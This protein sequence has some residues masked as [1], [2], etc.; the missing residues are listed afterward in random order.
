MPLLG[1]AQAGVSGYL[2]DAGYPVG[3]SWNEIRFPGLADEYAYALE[4]TGNSMEPAYRDGDGDIV[5]ISPEA[6]TRRGGRMVVKTI[7]GE[8]MAKQ[9]LRSSALKSN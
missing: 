9:L 2:D 7:D 8:N 1:F 3:G 4:I 6:N 5:I